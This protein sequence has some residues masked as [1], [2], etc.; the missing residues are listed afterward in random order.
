MRLCCG[1]MIRKNIFGVI[2]ISAF[3]K[4]QYTYWK[5][6]IRAL[7][8]KNPNILIFIIYGL[9]YETVMNIY[10]PFA[11]KFL[12][13]LGGTDFHITLYNAMPGLVGALALVPGIFYISRFKTKKNITSLFFFISRLFL[14]LIA[15]V[16]FLP[17]ELRPI[18][19]VALISI[20]NF[21]DALSQT[22]LQG[23]L[24]SVFDGRVRAEAIS[25]RNQFGYFI[26]PIVT[27]LTGIV[28]SFLPRDDSQKITYYQV[29]FVIAFLIGMLEIIIFR[30][31][32]EKPDH[33]EK[34]PVSALIKVFRDTKFLKFCISYLLVTFTWH[35]GWSLGN[36]FPIQY[37][38]ADEIWLA[39][40]S[41]A[42]GLG[43]FLSASYWSRLIR[44]KG[45]SLAL[46]IASCFLSI[47]MFGMVV[48]QL[49]FLI[50]AW[51]VGG[52][53]TIGINICILNGALT[54]T[55]DQDRLLYLG[56]Y[57]TG[58]NLS[59]FIAPLFSLMIMR[60]I[61]I[62]NMII[63]VGCLRILSGF[64]MYAAGKRTPEASTMD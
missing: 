39:V 5:F 50:P 61:G 43:S 30:R 12:Q 40:M 45:N 32:D 20:M 55:P 54:A 15:F 29:F 56:V 35:A 3:L 17:P 25:L 36:I 2:T 33:T 9:L 7:N 18:I 60:K 59:L 24:G 14:L 11:V 6:S 58:T 1:I 53:G 10:K 13:R 19:F 21:P 26:I 42:S 23:F 46:A 27:T 62:L 47:N 28:I 57:N 34:I 63:L 8:R 44:K 16:P 41:L 37:L 64:I 52:I 48:Q 49:W 4:K 38:G 22:S 51:F 31:F